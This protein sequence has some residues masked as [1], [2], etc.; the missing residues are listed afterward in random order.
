MRQEAFTEI[1]SPLFRGFISRMYVDYLDENKGSFVTDDDYATYV[2]SNFKFLV[3]KFN[4]QNGN[5]EW[6]IK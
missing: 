1:F 4:T 3:R 5:E 2:V 6:N